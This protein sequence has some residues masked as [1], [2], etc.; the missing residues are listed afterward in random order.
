MS[1]PRLVGV[2][3]GMGPLATLDFLQ[4]LLEVRAARRDQEHVPTVTWNVPQIPDRQLALAGGGADP[5]PAMLQGI[6]RLNAA[7]ASCIAI[8]CNTA[9]AWY[10]PLSA[11]SRAPIFHIVDATVQALLADAQQHRPRIG[12]IATRGALEQGLYQSR[13]EAAGL[14]YL[15][16]TPQELDQFFMPGCYAIKA[17]DIASGGRLLALSAEALLARGATRLVL[18]CTEVPIGLRHAAPEL[19]ALSVDPAT[20][21]AQACLRHWQ[22]S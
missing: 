12:L 4:R 5:L 16:P 6:E 9:H 18:A 8:P 2:L 15:T 19:L 10:E 7:G 20:A 21:L 17:H 11:H 14:D 22:Q 13:L 3:G 1:A